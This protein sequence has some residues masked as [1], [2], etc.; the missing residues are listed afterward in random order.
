MHRAVMLIATSFYWRYAVFGAGEIDATSFYWRY[1]VFGAGEIDATSFYW[2]YAVFGADINLFMPKTANRIPTRRYYTVFVNK[3]SFQ[4]NKKGIAV[5]QYRE[6]AWRQFCIGIDHFLLASFITKYTIFLA[7]SP[8]EKIFRFLIALR[9][10]SSRDLK[11]F[12]L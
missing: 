6:R 12:V 7:K 8:L 10:T 2:R 5:M 3:S 11:A 4:T 1:T 9:I